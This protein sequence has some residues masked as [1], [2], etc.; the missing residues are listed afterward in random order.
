MTLHP[1]PTT[2]PDPPT[3]AP[4]RPPSPNHAPS[5][6]PVILKHPHPLT[7]LPTLPSIPLLFSPSHDLE[8]RRLMP[9]DF[10]ISIPHMSF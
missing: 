10:T 6:P 8:I 9:T 1:L 2:R 4:T 7:H 5:H 3:P